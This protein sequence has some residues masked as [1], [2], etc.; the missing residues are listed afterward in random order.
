MKKRALSTLLALCLCL[1]LLPGTALAAGKY[2]LEEAEARGLNL[3]L[4]TKTL[5]FG[6]VEYREGVDL[7][8]E[9]KTV[10]VTNLGSE[11]LRYY[12]WSISSSLPI[13][14]IS[15]EGLTERTHYEEGMNE[16]G[17][18]IFPSI[19]AGWRQGRRQPSPS[20]AP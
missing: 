14:Q 13:E 2:T 18:G 3:G 9:I 15:A 5:D 7:F 4:N 6:T 11:D 12:G 8:P 1:G 17:W 10:T 16:H 19:P 20:D